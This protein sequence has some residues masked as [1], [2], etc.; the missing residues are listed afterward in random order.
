MDEDFEN[1]FKLNRYRVPC[2][3]GELTLHQFIYEWPQGFGQFS[4][5]AMNPNLGKLDDEHKRKLED[6]LGT[7]LR[8]IYKHF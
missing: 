8:V 5:E 6:I 4:V 2:C 3:C 1:G 7:P